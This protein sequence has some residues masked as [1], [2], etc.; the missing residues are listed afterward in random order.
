MLI[1]IDWGGT[2]I[3]GIALLPD[4]TEL[5]RERRDTPRHDY[6]G[7]IDM[8][9]SIIAD[10]EAKTGGRGTIGI[11]IPG[12]L[13]PKSR[14]GKGASSTW[15]LGR[16]V[17]T[18]L[19]ERL[20]REVR[21]E[22]DADCLAASE[23]VDGAG[24]GHNVVFAVILGSGAGAGIAVGGRAHHGPNNSGG[25]WGHNPLPF[26]NQSE[27]TGRPCY[28]GKHGCL[29]TWV[30][31]R[32]FEAEFALHTGTERKAAEIMEMKRGGDRLAGLLWS[33]YVDRVA[34]G[35][36]VV[37]NALDPDI[38]VMGGG[39]SNVP[40]LYDDLSP[41]IARYTFSTVFHT[42]IVKSRHGDSSGVRGAAWLWKDG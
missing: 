11:G 4:G 31:G 27:L 24:A 41:L 37:V 6:F 8:I 32:A 1:G 2:K 7:C 23:A 15:L 19:V 40:E 14:L 9:G 30:S 28:C 42:P 13:E 16:P 18:D 20:G 34:R 26:P 17:E 38:F 10:M 29:E 35:L 12:S 33:R 36:S 5:A 21:V 25:E 3:E 22:N 39:M